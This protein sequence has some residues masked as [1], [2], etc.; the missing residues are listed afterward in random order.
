MI[1]EKVSSIFRT[2]IAGAMIMTIANPVIAQDT[3][4]ARTGKLER[5]CRAFYLASCENRN[6]CKMDALCRTDDTTNDEK[7]SQVDLALRIGVNSNDGK[8]KWDGSNF[9]KKC[10]G[11]ALSGGWSGVTLE[12]TCEFVGCPDDTGESVFCVVVDV[13][14]ELS[15][16]DYYKVDDSGDIVEKDD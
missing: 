4:E 2:I 1:K 7:N 10:T 15:L 8:L 11:L 5:D 6:T 3:V 13:S 16:E 12:A 9:H 14:S